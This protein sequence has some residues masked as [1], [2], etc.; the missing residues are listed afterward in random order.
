M[1]AK[2]PGIVPHTPLM[3]TPKSKTAAADALVGLWTIA[4]A[5]FVVAG[6]Y[7]TRELLIPLALAALLTFL[8][9]P[10]VT[11]LERWIGRIA[12]VLLAVLLIFSVLGAAGYL[13]TRQLVDLATKLPDYKVN[14]AA[15]LHAFDAPR[16]GSLSK[17]SETM[18]ALKKELPGNSESPP[19]VVTQQPGKPE[20]AIATPPT[21]VTPALPV[22]VVETSKG[23]PIDLMKAIVAPL[24]GPLG[25]AALVLLLVIFML[26]Q[27]EDLRSRFI[28]LIGQGRISAT[29]RAMEDAGDRVSRYLRMQLLVNVTFGACVAVGLYFIGVPNALL[30][31]S[32]G[33][34]LR[35]IPYIGPWIA[36]LLPTAVALAVSPAW[37]MPLLTVALFIVIELVVANAIEPLLYGKHTGIS[38]IALIVAAVFWTWLWGPLGLMLSTPL[39][40]CLVV[41]GRHVPRLSFL[42][43]LLSDEEALTPAQECYHRLLIDGLDEAS[44]LAETFVK[45]NSL[46]A[47]YDAVLIPVVSAAEMDHRREALDAEQRT[48]VDQGVR[49]IVEDF[50]DR[51]LPA[52]K[53]DA[54]QLVAEHIPK[55]SLPAMDSR[56]YCLPARAERD[57]I[58]GQMLAQLLASTGA[59]VQNASARLTAGELIELAAQA[60]IDAVC[61]SVV[62]PS[63]V[64]HARYL[65]TKLRARLTKTKIVVGLWGA[66][67]NLTEAAQR[68]RDSGAD[69]VVTTLADAVVQIAKL[70]PRLSDE[71]MP[72]PIPTDEEQRLRALGELKLLDTAPD[73]LFDRITAKLARIFDVQIVLVSLVDRDRQ[74]FKSQSGLPAD[75]AATR[76]S[77]RAVS[78][79][80]HVVAEN[81]LIVVEDLAR[82]RRFA[83][84]PLLRERGLRFYAGAPLRAPNGQPIGT[85]C[86]L[87]PKPRQFSAREITLLE[88]YAADITEEIER[89]NSSA[90][91]SVPAAT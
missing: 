45:E 41:M 34:V 42:S 53:K 57:E 14:I 10:L 9:A 85:L 80:G 79:C 71:M 82:D 51:P 47:L 40:V 6:L 39:T 27:R 70:V 7:F 1:F 90:P 86:L 16:G 15:K 30:W 24:L 91:A 49:D 44:A 69:E 72:A 59:Q 32:L 67:E 77:P 78:I 60:E 12:A 37:L 52:S 63:T 13:L 81:E 29:A 50:G 36:T 17:F 88:E 33:T 26:L 21:P 73:P 11:R 54:D 68:L 5:A 55:I 25:T 74:F 87:D 84:N 46:T 61:I 31:G 65:A 22:K 48:A 62:A 23:N 35:F 66:T 4:L 83:N 56:I 18:E 38:S 8:I 75:L 2:L 19:L 3:Q 89:Q 28:R 64:I 43:T 58:A 76:E 20:T